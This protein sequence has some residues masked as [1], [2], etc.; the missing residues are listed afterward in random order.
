[1]EKPIAL[2]NDNFN[3]KRVDPNEL[4][5]FKEI[6]IG[7]GSTIILK[8]NRDGCFSGGS[9]YGSAPLS[10]DR[11]GNFYATAGEIAG[12]FT[13]SG[14]LFSDDGI[15]FQTEITLGKISFLKSG[16]EKSFI[17]TAS[18]SASLQCAVGDKFYVTLLSGVPIAYF[19]QNS[20]LRFNVNGEI[21]WANRKLT[22]SG[23]KIECDGDFSIAAG[24]SYRRGSD[25]GVDAESINYKDHDGNN[26]VALVRGGIITDVDA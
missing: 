9:S 16:A 18:D 13:V 8:A 24:Q 15:A 19:D 4:G 7:S 3:I 12:D 11:N 26:K 22:A 10:W 21:S 14:S 6:S 23:D 17:K 25:S 1:M 20:N 5:K 2:R